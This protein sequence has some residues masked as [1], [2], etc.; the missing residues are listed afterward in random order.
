MC[1]VDMRL[2]NQARHDFQSDVEYGSRISVRVRYGRLTIFGP[3]GTNLCGE[4]NDALLSLRL[5]AGVPDHLAPLAEL[6]LDEALKLL[7]RA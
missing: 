1:F 6:D 2:P 3:L 4:A 5:N 7:G